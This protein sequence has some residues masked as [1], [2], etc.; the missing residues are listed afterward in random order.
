MRRTDQKFSQQ[1]LAAQ[2]IPSLPFSDK[3]GATNMSS[4]L[5]VDY[6]LNRKQVEL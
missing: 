2:K 3:Y 1:H 4:K 5:E 6:E